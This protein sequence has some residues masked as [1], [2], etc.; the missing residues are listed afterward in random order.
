M[1]TEEIIIKGE[2]VTCPSCG[3]EL[4]LNKLESQSRIFFCP[5][6][7]KQQNL[8]PSFIDEIVVPIVR[9]KKITFS[10]WEWFEIWLAPVLFL[11]FSIFVFTQGPIDSFVVGIGNYTIFIIGLFHLIRG[12][13]SSK[14]TF[15]PNDDSID[16]KKKVARLLQKKYRWDISEAKEDTFVFTDN[17]FPSRQ[18]I[19]LICAEEGYYLHCMV[20]AQRLGSGISIFQTTRVVNFINKISTKSVIN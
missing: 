20:R 11:S 7:G 5:D 17:Y 15:I 10:T 19:I 9:Q 4:E 18:E 13:T 3:I 1:K 16:K 6:C 8:D 2:I 12:I 14:L